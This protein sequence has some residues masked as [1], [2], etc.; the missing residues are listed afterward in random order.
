MLEIVF[1]GT[2]DAFGS[3]GR[4]N[5]AILVRDGRHTLLLDC[6]PTTHAGLNA[7]GIDAREI[8]AIALSH[9][10]GDHTAG[11]PFLLLA[12]VYERPRERPLHIL[13]P[14]EVQQRVE[15]MNRAF[16]Y[17]PDLKRTYP[18]RFTE[19]RTGQDVEAASFTLRPSPAWHHPNTKPFML[20]V[21]SGA[22][23][24]FF[25]GDTGWHEAL[26]EVVGD[27]DL[28]I[29]ECVF[30]ESGFEYHLSHNQLDRERQ[31]FKCERVILTHLGSEVLDNMECVRFD[32]AHDGL[33]LK[34]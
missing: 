25:T 27:V 18:L 23:R 16:E 9:Y 15:D 24:L 29:S 22:Q 12:F 11:L 5:S 6:G 32:T 28:L 2:G 8:D 30:V 14:P 33:K 13:G 31:R 34:I 26:P 17:A 1:V 21:R 19:F 4:R 3:G 20:A 10:H 7:L